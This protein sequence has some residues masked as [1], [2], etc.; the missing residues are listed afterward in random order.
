V[1]AH[2][3]DPKLGRSLNSLSFSLCSIF[4]PTF[5]LERNNSG[6]K[7]FVMGLFRFHILTVWHFSYCHPH[8][9]L[10]ASLPH[11]WDFLMVPPVLHPTLLHIYIHSSGPLGFSPVSNTSPNLILPPYSLH[12]SSHNQVPPS[13][14]LL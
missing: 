2:G 11:I 12:V 13:F 5:S 8:C 7:I 3:M 6:P 14:Y 10:A 9:V 4:V 1:S